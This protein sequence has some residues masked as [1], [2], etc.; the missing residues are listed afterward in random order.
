MEI[1]ISKPFIDSNIYAHKKTSS[2]F[3]AGPCSEKLLLDYVNTVLYSKSNFSFFDNLRK[4]PDTPESRTGVFQFYVA[5]AVFNFKPNMAGWVAY[6][7][8]LWFYTENGQYL[9]RKT[10]EMLLS[11]ISEYGFQEYTYYVATRVFSILYL[12]FFLFKM[13]KMKKKWNNLEIYIHLYE[14]IEK[15]RK[16][17]FN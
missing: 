17:Y 14:P 15:V 16:Y 8:L 2:E 12:P 10:N 11:R 6:S 4:L 7:W 3:I 5:A 13:R 1:Q 9:W